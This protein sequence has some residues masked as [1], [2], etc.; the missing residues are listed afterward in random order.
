MK[1]SNR[2]L[3]D[4]AIEKVREGNKADYNF[5]YQFASKWVATTFKP[6]TT[7]DFKIDLFKQYKSIEIEEPRV[8]GAVFNE[9]AKQG[10]IKPTG[11]F[12]T[13]KEST[14]HSRPKREWISKAYSE[15]QSENRKT[16]SESEQVTLNLF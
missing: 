13:S 10:F 11:R 7:D 9:L 16:K 1:K 8:I 6:F 15:K 5:L 14:C 4:E 3:T 2:Q 12:I